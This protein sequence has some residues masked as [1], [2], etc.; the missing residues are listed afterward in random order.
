MKL[1]HC[2]WGTAVWAQGASGVKKKACLLFFKPS[3]I[4]PFVSAFRKQVYNNKAWAKPSKTR[5]CAKKKNPERRSLLIQTYSLTSKHQLG[6]S[7]QEAALPKAAGGRGGTGGRGRICGYRQKIARANELLVGRKTSHSSNFL[8]RE[9]KHWD[10]AFIRESHFGCYDGENDRKRRDKQR[11]GWRAEWGMTAG[12][13]GLCE[14][15]GE[16]L[17]SD[18]RRNRLLTSYLGI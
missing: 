1:T 6:S 11:V 4:L 10:Q 12:K 16:H 14:T 15:S 2:E 7:Q 3:P 8:R 5:P 17:L 9:K 13:W 18:G